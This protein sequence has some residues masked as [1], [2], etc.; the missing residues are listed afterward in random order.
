MLTQHRRSTREAGGSLRELHRGTRQPQ[1]AIERVVEGLEE[2]RDADAVDGGEDDF[3]NFEARKVDDA[4][5]QDLGYA[6][7]DGRAKR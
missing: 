1:P 2:T 7:P 5:V 3:T 4:D 6:G